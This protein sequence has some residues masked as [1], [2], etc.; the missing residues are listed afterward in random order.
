MAWWRC[1]TSSYDDAAERTFFARLRSVSISCL[2]AISFLFLSKRYRTASLA[3]GVKCLVD[4][5]KLSSSSSTVVLCLFSSVST[6]ARAFSRASTSIW[7]PKPC[8]RSNLERPFP[9]KSNNTAVDSSSIERMRHA[10]TSFCI[11]LSRPP[12]W[13]IFE[14]SNPGTSFR[15]SLERHSP[16]LLSSSMSVAPPPLPPPHSHSPTGSNSSRAKSSGQ[17]C[18]SI[19]SNGFSSKALPMLSIR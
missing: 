12:N 8:F 5:S 13:S 4:D 11:S 14:L 10:F 9:S 16:T 17:Y 15:R 18:A 6:I 1:T 2:L 3:A 19:R 7:G